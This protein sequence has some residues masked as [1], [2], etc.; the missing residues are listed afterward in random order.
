MKEPGS[1]R[2]KPQ[3]GASSGHT[4]TTECQGE[5]RPLPGMGVGN[6]GSITASGSLGANP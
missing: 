5:W 2:W 4:P 1:A 6:Q 3:D